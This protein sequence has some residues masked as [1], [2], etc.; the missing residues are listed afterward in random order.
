M[1]LCR[2]RFG[3]GT[4]LQHHRNAIHN[5]IVAATTMTMQPCV[6]GIVRTRGDGPM[7][8]RANKNIEQSRG[9]NGARHAKSLD[10]SPESIFTSA[11]YRAT[12][13]IAAFAQEPGV[14]GMRA[15]WGGRKVAPR[16][17]FPC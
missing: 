14:P 15:C 17:A 7:A 13:S 6:R 11:V 8:Y 12:T 5:R 3:L 2:R 9:K 16:S 4:L 10:L 1:R